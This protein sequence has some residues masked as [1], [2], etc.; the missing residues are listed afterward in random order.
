MT[1]FLLLSLQP[2]HPHSH[3]GPQHSRLSPG[4]SLLLWFPLG[5]SAHTS[6]GSQLLLPLHDAQASPPLAGSG[7]SLDSH[8]SRELH[9]S[10]ELQLIGVGTGHGCVRSQGAYGGLSCGCGQREL[11]L[12]RPGTGQH[13]QMLY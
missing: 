10:V 6:P 3:P 12:D 2:L 4:E 8:S 9:L 5:R 1:L 11:R 7:D 13:Q